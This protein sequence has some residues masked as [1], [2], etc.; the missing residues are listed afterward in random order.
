MKRP[1]NKRRFVPAV[2]LCVL[3]AVVICGTVYAYMFHRTG[4][5]GTTFTPATVSCKVAEEFNGTEKSSITVQ[6][7]SNI[8][9]YLRVRLV[10]YWVNGEGEV[11]AKSSPELSIEYDSTKWIK[12]GDSDT[13]YCK[14]PVAPD[15]PNNVTPELLT[16][17]IELT[18]EDGFK[19]VVDV[20]A[21]A[22]QA[23]PAKA[24][25]DSWK[26]TLS[27]TTITDAP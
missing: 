25:K 27:G 24:V 2:L 19:Q 5:E 9:A 7:T 20:F 18:V 11:A 22:I 4:E 10:T 1:P 15:A 21:E 8:P 14:T 6:N 13:F 12:D 16:L 17:P 23:E 26:V 3:A